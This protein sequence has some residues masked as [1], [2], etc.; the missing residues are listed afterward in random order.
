MFPGDHYFSASR[1]LDFWVALFFPR[2]GGSVFSLLPGKYS[3]HDLKSREFPRPGPREIMVA[4][5][6]SYPGCWKKLRPGKGVTHPDPKMS[7]R[8]RR[9]CRQNLR[10]SPV[11][12]GAPG[13]H[14]LSCLMKQRPS[15]PPHDL[16]NPPRTL[17]THPDSPQNQVDQI[18]LI[19]EGQ[20]IRHSGP[21]SHPTTPEPLQTQ[22]M[23][24]ACVKSE[25]RLP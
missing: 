5:K 20:I 4:P 14:E 1:K 21:L 15:W 13:I 6:H 23:Y 22:S 19:F 25:S 7:G 17:Q 3:K 8:A 9:S 24:S 18:H 16:P 12:K 2:M 11:P 10:G